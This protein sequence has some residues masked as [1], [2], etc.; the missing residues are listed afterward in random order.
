VLAP[1]VE[2]AAAGWDERELA[3]AGEAARVISGECS[4]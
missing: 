4:L 2:V 1:A 3:R